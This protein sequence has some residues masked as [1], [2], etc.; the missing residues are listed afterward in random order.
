MGLCVLSNVFAKTTEN[1]NVI[2]IMT[3]A[4][5]GKQSSAM[6]SMSSPDIS[7]RLTKKTSQGHQC[8]NAA[9]RCIQTVRTILV[10]VALFDQGSFEN[11]CR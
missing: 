8:V 9:D 7:R 6:F 3:A 5:R 2:L 11:G 1:I 10:K 4:I